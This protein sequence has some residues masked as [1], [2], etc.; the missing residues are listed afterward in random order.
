LEC[1]LRAA[2]CVPDHVHLLISIPPK[3]AVAE[4][5]QIIKGSSSH[6]VSHDVEGGNK[7][8]EWQ[9]GYGVLSLSKRDLKIVSRYVE[10]QKQRHRVGKIWEELEKTEIE[11]G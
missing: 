3:L 11:E 8:F 2:N 9:R 4:F 10:T 5:A 7:G 1:A 6:Y